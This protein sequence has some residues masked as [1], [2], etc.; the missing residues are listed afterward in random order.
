MEA[1]IFGQTR[2]HIAPTH[3]LNAPEGRVTTALQGLSKAVP[4][5]LSGPSNGATTTHVVALLGADGRA[6]LAADGREQA[7]FLDSGT[8]RVEIG[9]RAKN[10]TPGGFGYIPG[11]TPA[12]L[13]AEGGEATVTHPLRAELL[14]STGCDPAGPDV[15]ECFGDRSPTGLPL[16]G[17]HRPPR[18]PAWQH[19]LGFGDGC[20]HLPARGSPPPPHHPG[21]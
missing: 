14:G 8:L 7:F 19:R 11:D 9:S 1:P 4:F 10:L 15:R 2:S 20:L 17:R 16:A 3:I 5:V 13:K 12:T 6:T 18:T 21:D